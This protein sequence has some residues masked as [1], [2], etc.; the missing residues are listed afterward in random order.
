GFPHMIDTYPSPRIRIT[1]IRAT[2]PR[3]RV[4][5]TARIPS[6]PEGEGKG[7]GETSRTELRIPHLMAPAITNASPGSIGSIYEGSFVFESVKS[8]KTSQHHLLK[9]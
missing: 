8:P 4:A 3:R 2:P 6:P 7:E 9:Y 1:P 5:V